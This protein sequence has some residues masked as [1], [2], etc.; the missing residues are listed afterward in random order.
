MLGKPGDRYESSDSE[1]S[2]DDGMTAAQAADKA[3]RDLDQIRKPT[4]KK[5]PWADMAVEEERLQMEE[6]EDVDMHG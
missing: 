6:E 1:D 5:N 3:R 2:T 4:G